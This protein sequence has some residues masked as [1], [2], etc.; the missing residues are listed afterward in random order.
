[1]NIDK[2]NP[3]DKV[4]ALT[5]AQTSFEVRPPRGEINLASVTERPEKRVDPSDAISS[6]QLRDSVRML[7]SFVELVSDKNLSISL[8]EELSKIVVKV[9]NKETEEVIKQIPSEEALSL[10]KELRNLSDEYFG[11]IKGIL[12]DSEV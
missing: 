9:L 12:L 11:D 7:S 3:I 1:M 10:M 2:T 5:A 8:D 4:G 6:Q